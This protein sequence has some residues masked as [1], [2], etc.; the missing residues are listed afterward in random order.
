[1]AVNDT[2]YVSVEN[3]PLNLVPPACLTNGGTASVNLVVRHN[4]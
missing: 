1:M 3:Y 4:N 2:V